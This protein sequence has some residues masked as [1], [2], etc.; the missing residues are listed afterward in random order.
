MDDDEEYLPLED[1]DTISISESESEGEGKG[2]DQLSDISENGHFEWTEDDYCDIVEHIYQL[3]DSYR[4]N[5]HSSLLPPFYDKMI[6]EITDHLFEIWI[7][8]D[9][10]GEDDG[11]YKHIHQLVSDIADLYMDSVVTTSFQSP[12][13]SH[14]VEDHLTEKIEW[15]RSIPQPKQR[16]KEWYEFR[17]NLLTAS[18]IWK[19]LSS[20]QCSQNSLIYEKCKP[21]LLPNTSTTTT[22]ENTDTDK[23]IL[24]GGEKNIQTRQINTNSPLHWG[25][26]YEPLS[27][28]IYE[29][30]F[31]TKVGDFGCIQHPKYPFIGASPDGINIDKN[32]PLLYGR[33]LEI[34]NIVNRP[35]TGIPKEEYWIQTQV[36]METCDLDYCDFFETRFKEFEDADSFYQSDSYKFKGI[37]LYFVQN[38]NRIPSPNSTPIQYDHSPKYVYMPLS[39]DVTSMDAIQ[40]WISTTRNSMKPEYILYTTLYWY[41]EEYS[42]VLIERNRTW[43]QNALPKISDIWQTILKERANGYEHR[44]PTRRKKNQSTTVTVES[45]GDDNNTRNNVHMIRNLPTKTPFCLVKLE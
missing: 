12:S 31:Q 30:M 28:A 24:V 4:E 33:M 32:N 19:A 14:V 42:C 13:S 11:D 10:C 1:D 3:I 22:D 37:I 17:Y 9:L 2:E 44:A 43:F 29:H 5:T 39:L 41:L 21:L 38:P 25:V 45:N 40:E 36:Q 27:V 18:N 26:K 20:S 23:D 16:S 34:K 6:V 15:L 7:D 35:I 8:A